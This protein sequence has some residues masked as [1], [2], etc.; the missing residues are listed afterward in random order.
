M[1]S[2][3]ITRIRRKP[4]CL[5]RSHS[6]AEVAQWC[7]WSRIPIVWHNDAMSLLDP[8]PAKQDHLQ[9]LGAALRAARQRQGWMQSDEF[10]KHIGVPGRT[11][12]K[13]E[14]TGQ[15]SVETL[16]RA[17]DKLDTGIVAALI[18]HIEDIDEHFESI[19]EALGS[20]KP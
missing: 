8:R 15:G 4:P 2:S 14:K 5:V 17:L 16:I 19:D 1:E 13:L 20:K 10:G 9:R 6:S 11:L 3:C 7:R 12:R 18:Q